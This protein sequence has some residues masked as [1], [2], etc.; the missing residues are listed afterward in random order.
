[1]AIVTNLKKTVG[2]GSSLTTNPNQ[3]LT[4]INRYSNTADFTIT[5]IP[6]GS[7]YV[8]NAVARSITITMPIPTAADE[9]KTFWIAAAGNDVTSQIIRLRSTD[10]AGTRYNGT[11][12]FTAGTPFGLDL[13]HSYPTAE[14]TWT[15]TDYGWLVAIAGKD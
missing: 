15:N 3:N 11:S 8:L 4:I 10:P 6:S 9:G 5:S 2:G 1:M 7:M 14:I 12:Y 13:S